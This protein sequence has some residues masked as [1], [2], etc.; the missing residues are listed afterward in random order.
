[1]TLVY[2]QHV[3]GVVPVHVVAVRDVARQHK[4]ALNS[5]LT[6]AMRLSERTGPLMHQ[7]TLVCFTRCVDETCKHCICIL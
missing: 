7:H 4:R 3:F 5:L 6:M 2:H 1:M